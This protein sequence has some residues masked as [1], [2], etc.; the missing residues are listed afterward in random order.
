MKKLHLNETYTVN[1]H[2]TFSARSQL[3]RDYKKIGD[4]IYWLMQKACVIKSF[5]SESDKTENRRLLNLAPI[6]N[7][8]VFE[9][10]GNAYQFYFFKDCAVLG[11]FKKIEVTE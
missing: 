9:I 8:D 11:T 5:Y 4:G 10:D 3:M 7:G 2:K 1:I 6:N